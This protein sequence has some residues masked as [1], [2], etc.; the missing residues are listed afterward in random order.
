MKCLLI[1]VLLITSILCCKTENLISQHRIVISTDFP[2]LDVCMSGC[3]S[4]HTSDPD[5][6]QSMV[7]FLLYGNEF[8]IEGLIAS[9][10]TFANVARKQNILDILELYDQVDENLRKHDT[11]YP[12]ANHLRKV[13]YE[14]LS[15][16]YGKSIINNIGEGK[17]SEASRA[18]IKIIDKPDPRPVWFC[19]WGDCS[20]IAQ[21]I[22]KVKQ[23]RSA[24]ELE[25]FLSK[26][27]IYQIAHQDYTI[28]W[29]MAN[30]PDLFIIYSN[31]TFMGFFGGPDDPLGDHNWINTNIRQNHGPL[32]AIYPLAAM[33]VDGLKE[34]DSPSFMYLVSASYGL[35]NSE[36]PS[37]ESW[38][39]QYVR[40][41]STNHWVD[42]IG[43][44]TISKWKENYQADF[45]KRADRM[46]QTY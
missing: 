19:V 27:R 11:R 30:F 2:P 13:T 34:G 41:D 5:D 17:D 15:G 36:N 45:A 25:I 10:A 43:G 32:G 24:E 31:S 8:E 16:T 40:I 14:G 4:D 1:K 18:I 33:G 9:S 37:L 23:T 29:L 38:G 21:A 3:P 20:N 22:W 35:S 7:R 44:S 6:I 26:I 46:L 28:D 39:G 12:T 42:G